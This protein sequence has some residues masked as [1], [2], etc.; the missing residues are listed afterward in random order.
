[1][2]KKTMDSS[3]LMVGLL[4]VAVGVLLLLDTLGLVEDPLRFWPLFLIVLGIIK[5][6]S[7]EPSSRIIGSVLIAVGAL[8][9]ISNLGYIRIRVRDLWPVAIIFRGG[10]VM[11]RALGGDRPTEATDRVN[12]VGVLG[13]VQRNCSTQDFQGGELTAVMGGCEIDF[14]EASIVNSPA[15]IEVFAMWGGIQL[16][17]PEDWSVSIETRAIL[18]G[19][20][21]KTRPPKGGSDKR[22][23]LKGYAVMGGVEVRN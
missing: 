9:L 11:L 18:G 8:F 10:A 13:G 3:Q 6:R 21:D 19:V 22:L 2:T 15:V 16:K 4:V 14:R 20:V 23:V 7:T 17:V 12:D 5:L 1:M